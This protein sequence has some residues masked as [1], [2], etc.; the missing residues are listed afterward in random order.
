VL[1]LA[2]AVA[3]YVLIGMFFTFAYKAAGEFGSVPF[4]GAAGHGTLSQDLFSA[5]SR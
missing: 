3:A 4:F 5:S 2:G 1:C